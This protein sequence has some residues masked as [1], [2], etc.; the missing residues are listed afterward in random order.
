MALSTTLTNER[1]KASTLLVETGIIR[2]ELDELHIKCRGKY[3]VLCCVVL[4]CA[5]CV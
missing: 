1:T 4:C 2:K 5:V 3:D